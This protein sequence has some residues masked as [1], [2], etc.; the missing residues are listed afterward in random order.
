M[1]LETIFE[2]RF[3]HVPELIRMG[4]SIRVEDRV[5]V[6]EGGYRLQGQTCAA[7]ICAAARRCCWLA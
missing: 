4:A 1:F 2:N 5:A 6:I 3:M 7:P